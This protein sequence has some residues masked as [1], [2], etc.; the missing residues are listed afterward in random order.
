MKPFTYDI[1]QWLVL[2]RLFLNYECYFNYFQLIGSHPSFIM[3]TRRNRKNRVES[4]VY[5]NGQDV[6][7]QDES[8][9]ERIKARFWRSL[10][11]ICFTKMSQRGYRN[12][13]NLMREQ[14]KRNDQ[15]Q[16]VIHPFSPFR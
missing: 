10:K 15:N 16:F 1:I 3:C 7:F 4:E 6:D 2:Y 13:H 11:I 5:V 12:Q 9:W 14:N 8:Y